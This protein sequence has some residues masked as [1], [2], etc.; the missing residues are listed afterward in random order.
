MSEMITVVG[1]LIDNALDAGVDPQ[2]PWVE[3]TIVGDSTRL[4][5]T[6]TDSGRE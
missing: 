6:V 3:V 1:N 2:D 4:E 5:I